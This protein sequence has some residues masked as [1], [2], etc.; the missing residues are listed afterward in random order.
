MIPAMPD[1]MRQA[2]CGLPLFQEAATKGDPHY[3]HTYTQLWITLIRI[4]H[5]VHNVSKPSISN[6]VR[7]HTDLFTIVIHE[8]YPTYT[9]VVHKVLHIMWKTTRM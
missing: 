6:I 7:A 8:L 3:S 9:Q 5:I 4:V 1:E 2:I